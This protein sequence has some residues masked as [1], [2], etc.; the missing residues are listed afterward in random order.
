MDAD[1]PEIASYVEN[2]Y[3]YNGENVYIE[4]QADAVQTHNGADAIY[5][6]WGVRATCDA[7][8]DGNIVEVNGVSAQ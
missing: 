4:L 6:A 1:S 5:A 7:V 2:I 8:D 3:L